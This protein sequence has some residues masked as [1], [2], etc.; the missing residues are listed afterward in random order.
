MVGRPNIFVLFIILILTGVLTQK[1][2]VTFIKIPTTLY[3]DQLNVII[4]TSSSPVTK[5]KI[6][7]ILPNIRRPMTKRVKSKVHT[8]SGGWF[9]VKIPY[10]VPFIPPAYQIIDA[11]LNFTVQQFLTTSTSRSTKTEL[12]QPVKIGHSPRIIL[13]ETDKPLYRPGETVRARLV[14]LDTQF[15]LPITKPLKLPRKIL[16]V[17]SEEVSSLRRLSNKERARLQRVVY[18]EISITDASGARVRRW[19]NATPVEAAS[20]R[21]TLLPN[22]ALGTWIITAR[23]M[24][25]QEVMKFEVRNYGLPRFRITIDPPSDLMFDSEFT[26]FSVCATYTDGLPMI[27]SVRA[28]LCVCPRADSMPIPELILERSKCPRISGYY[29]EER[30]CVSATRRLSS[31]GCASFDVST[32]LLQLKN[33]S[34]QKYDLVTLVCAEVVE[35]DTNTKVSR[36]VYGSGMNYQH[37]QLKL[38]FPNTYR[39]GLPLVG[40]AQL[41]NPKAWSLYDLEVQITVS[42]QLDCFHQSYPY[43]PRVN[44]LFTT[45]V[46][47]DV[48]G[49]ASILIPPIN[50]TY[51]ISVEV[52][53]DPNTNMNT[54]S[55]DALPIGVLPFPPHRDD[56]KVRAHATLH[57]WESTSNVSVQVGLTGRPSS[58]DCPGEVTLRLIAN[59]PLSAQM[60]HLETVVRGGHLHN[61]IPPSSDSDQCQNRDGD[62]G[63]YKCENPLGNKIECLP[64]WQ[65]DDCLRAVCS[66]NCNPKGGSCG[67]PNTCIC[68]EGWDGVDCDKCIR[69]AGCVNGK[70]VEGNDCVC[71]PGW[72]GY[73]CDQK[74]Q[75]IQT[76]THT[77]TGENLLAKRQVTSEYSGPPNRTIYERIIRFPIDGQWGPRAEVVLYFYLN[78]DQLTD[79][80]AGVFTL[81]NLLNCASPSIVLE[82]ESDT[83]GL[84]FDRSHSHP[85]QN[86][87]VTLLPKGAVLPTNKGISGVGGQLTDQVCF[88]RISDIALDNFGAAANLLSLQSYATKLEMFDRLGGY[89]PTVANNVEQAFQSAGLL[90]SSNT[91]LQRGRYIGPVC[92]YGAGQNYLYAST[93]EEAVPPSK[94]QFG[95]LFPEVWLFDV[96]PI[97]NLGRSSLDNPILGVRENLVVS[98]TITTWR[99][100]AFCTTSS[101]GLWIPPTQL[102]TVSLPFSIQLTLPKQLKRYEILYL[103]VSVFV[104]GDNQRPTSD[105]ANQCY[106]IEL[107]AKLNVTEWS[108]VGAR[109]FSACVCGGEKK[110]FF[111]GIQPL[112]IGK[113]DV[114]VEVT[115]SN[116]STLC[117]N[118]TGQSNRSVTQAEVLKDTVSQQIDVQSEGIP[119][120]S[121]YGDILCLNGDQKTVVRDFNLSIPDGIIPN[122]LQVYLSYSDE[123]FG[124]ALL[125]LDSLI[126]LPTGCGEQNMLLV[127]SNVYVLSYFHATPGSIT[128]RADSLTQRAR[129][130]IRIGYERELGFQRNDGSFSTFGEKDEFGSTW[131]TALVLRVFAKAYKVDSTLFS[132]FYQFTS[133]TARFLKQ[134]QNTTGCFYER[135]RVLYTPMQGGLGSETLRDKDLLLTAYVVSAIL[136]V[137]KALGERYFTDSATLLANGFKCLQQAIGNMSNASTGLQSVSTYGLAQLAYAH[138]LYQSN[139]STTNTLKQELVKRRQTNAESGSGAVTYWTATNSSQTESSAQIT[140]LDVETTSY[141]YLTLAML[142]ATNSELLPIIRW[143]STKQTSS[144]G[145]YS[146]QDTALALEAISDFARRF[147]LAD[148]TGSSG[149]LLV[150]SRLEPADFEL[151]DVLTEDKSR[152][153][154]QVLSPY[155]DPKKIKTSKWTLSTDTSA[156]GCIAVQTALRYNVPFPNNTVGTFFAIQVTVN[157]SKPLPKNSRKSI[158]LNV[159]LSLPIDQ[160]R[161]SETGMLLITVNM[162]SGWLS[163]QD[164][165]MK[166]IG[167]NR[168][169]LRRAEFAEDGTVYLYFDG[170]TKNEVNNTDLASILI[171]QAKPAKI[172]AVDYYAPERTVLA[173]YTL[174]S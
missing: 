99:A 135:G 76:G 164:K 117:S 77:N 40:S 145:F 57:H 29:R 41:I 114:T 12:S 110:I 51:S 92:H 46:K 9:E 111:L 5:I 30:A 127:T 74:Q 79:V 66:P 163:R 14:V 97:R 102:L 140:A 24:G 16:S 68:Y 118:R 103:P 168:E 21:Y 63:H 87:T 89:R 124:P 62:L 59:T 143:L 61:I 160:A 134:T 122:S 132:E 81:D 52:I 126:S 133:Q 7:T 60:I 98:D 166:Q 2:P 131:L 58:V 96:F 137:K 36:C 172:S 6:K 20:L 31:D 121:T 22:A 153:A 47:T 171:D 55:G 161:Q 130:N 10:Q 17:E 88:A 151:N 37:F 71:E 152:T 109:N 19:V 91:Q 94:P 69:R 155:S 157:Q 107:T 86:I 112:L 113:F 80:V 167:T 90:V 106:R 129:S 73:N 95:D 120:E 45:K 15:T 50:S 54:A 123:V 64:G 100:S 33:N 105:T 1:S 146:T 159:C 136:E 72:E 83:P 149:P 43:L 108:P 39:T 150:N 128:E 78:T 125:H 75:H 32:G 119:K 28:S 42:E 48:N 170:F 85:G 173:M 34:L 158:Q 169:S 53:Y 144:G 101:S 35:R 154:N 138:T 174:S 70:C 156:I 67:Q 4:I 26:H 147:G 165:I 56:G 44:R 18:D 142:N 115:A 116:N 49:L 141:A 23:V 3:V 148:N 93:R 38:G 139:S 25:K 82:S 84:R 162:V 27:G 104:T 13:S 11:R 65:G 8:L